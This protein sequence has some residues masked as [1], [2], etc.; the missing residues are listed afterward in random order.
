MSEHVPFAFGSQSNDMEIWLI[1]IDLPIFHDVTLSYISLDLPFNYSLYVSI[2]SFYHIIRKYFSIH[3]WPSAYL[4]SSS[5]L[6]F[7]E[8]I[9]NI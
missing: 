5:K 8:W 3:Y 6:F 9:A 1:L 2:L 4:A 7:V